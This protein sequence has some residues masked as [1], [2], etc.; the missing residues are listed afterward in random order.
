MGDSQGMAPRKNDDNPAPGKTDLTGRSPDVPRNRPFGPCRPNVSNFIQLRLRGA[1]GARTHDRRIMRTTARRS[2]R[3]TCTDTT[4]PCHRWP[5]LH[6]MHG[7]LG[8]RTGPRPPQRAPDINYG[9]SPHTAR[10]SFCI[11]TALQLAPFEARR[12]GP[13]VAGYL[14]ADARRGSGAGQ[15]SPKRAMGMEEG[16]VVCVWAV[17]SRSSRSALIQRPAAPAMVP[18]AGGCCSR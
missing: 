1:D 14:L 6:C 3:S 16:R 4:E 10:E 13:S 17:K 8:P 2:R 15:V 9:A 5:S 11:V 7:W 12:T 18:P